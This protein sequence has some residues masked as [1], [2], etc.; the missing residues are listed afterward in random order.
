[1]KQ[2][3]RTADSKGRVALPGFAGATVIVEQVDDTEFRVRKARESPRRNC[4][5]TR[6]S[7][8]CNSRRRT[9][10]RWSGRWPTRPLP[11]RPPAAPP[12][13]S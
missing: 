3:I 8:S 9:P 13:N 1:M 5:S 11:A 2:V 6:K 4:T 10:P 12:E 7:F